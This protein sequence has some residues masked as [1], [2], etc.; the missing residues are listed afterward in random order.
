MIYLFKRFR[1]FNAKN[2]V[3]VGQRASKLPAFK[4]GGLK[5]KSASQPT[6]VGFK[7]RGHFKFIFVK[8]SDGVTFED[9]RRPNE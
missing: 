6:V 4:V 8:M 2:F 9:V 5:K 1:S 3:S 7:L